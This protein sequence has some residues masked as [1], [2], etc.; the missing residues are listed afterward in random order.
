MV[1]RGI[2]G[3]RNAR[4]KEI[5]RDARPET[6]RSSL[7]RAE[8]TLAAPPERGC[9]EQAQLALGG[10]MERDDRQVPP[11]DLLQAHEGKIFTPRM[12]FSCHNRPT[13]NQ[14]LRAQN[15]RK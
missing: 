10:A 15:H 8:R 4:W 11:A 2:A 6:P 7:A 1:E 5:R 9:D 14:E 13:R 12:F 3:Q